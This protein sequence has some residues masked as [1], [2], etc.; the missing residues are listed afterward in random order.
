VSPFSGFLSPEEIFIISEDLNLYLS[1]TVFVGILAMCYPVPYLL[2]QERLDKVE[3]RVHKG[4][5]IHHVD[6]LQF[7]WIRL[8]NKNMCAI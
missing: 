8:L 3:Y 5:H 6:F 4:R 7:H 1:Q 2:L